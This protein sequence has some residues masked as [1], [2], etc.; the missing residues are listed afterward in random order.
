MKHSQPKF[1]FYEKVRVAAPESSNV[2]RLGAVSGK[3]QSDEGIWV[4]SVSLYAE[5]SCSCFDEDQLE[6][7][8]EFAERSEFYAGDSVRVRVDGLGHGQIVE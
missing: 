4:Y 5:T 3:S 7:I 8:G 2:G 6:S 1:Q